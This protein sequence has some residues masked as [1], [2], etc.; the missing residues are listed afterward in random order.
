VS[1]YNEN[2]Q[3]FNGDRN[4]VLCILGEMQSPLQ[5]TDV[6]EVAIAWRKHCHVGWK[7]VLMLYGKL[8]DNTADNVKNNTMR[9]AL[10]ITRYPLNMRSG[11]IKYKGCAKPWNK[12]RHHHWQN[13]HCLSHSLLWRFCHTCL[14]RREL[15]H[16]VFTSLDFATVFSLTK[17]V[18]HS[19]AFN[20]QPGGPG[21]CIYIPQWQGG[22]I[23]VATRSNAW[24]V[25]DRLNTGN[26]GS[27][28][29]RGMDVCVR[30]FC[31]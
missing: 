2:Q 24:T 5:L 31:L 7:P 18:H 27:N 22:P 30:L 12:S 4:F 29:T 9:C 8:P 20:H 17:Q 15:D 1:A 21:L 14:F 3:K 28:P 11:S 10:R 6:R 16:A 23:T 25:F 19:L 26:V 13:C